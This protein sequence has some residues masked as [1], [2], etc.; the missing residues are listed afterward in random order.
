MLALLGLEHLTGSSRQT[1]VLPLLA[2]SE[3]PKVDTSELNSVLK[4]E[5]Q[6]FAASIKENATHSS[7]P[8]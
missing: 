4:S 7:C 1:S 6:E 5:T 2:E 3:P 8:S